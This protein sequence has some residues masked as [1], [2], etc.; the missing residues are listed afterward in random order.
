MKWKKQKGGFFAMLLGALGPS[1]LG[2]I[3]PGK[4][5][6]GIVCCMSLIFI[7]LFSSILFNWPSLSKHNPH[8]SVFRTQSNFSVGICISIFAKRPHDFLQLTY[9]VKKL[10]CRS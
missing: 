2:N 4:G 9:F 3:L 8:V 1:M 5:V 7:L 6:A 10:H